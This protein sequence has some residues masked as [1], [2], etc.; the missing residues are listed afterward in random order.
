MI[1]W[2]CFAVALA[3]VFHRSCYQFC[4]WGV[5]SLVSGECDWEATGWLSKS[6]LPFRLW[7]YQPF[8]SAQ[9]EPGSRCWNGTLVIGTSSSVELWDQSE[10]IWMRQR[11]GESSCKK[12]HTLQRGSC[13]L[14]SYLVDKIAQGIL[15]NSFPLQAQAYMYN[16]WWQILTFIRLDNFVSCL[17][18]NILIE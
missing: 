9:R 16:T 1:S 14:I 10:K 5:D 15:Q 4:P 17:Q 12:W 8:P 6:S 2:Y 11:D 18:L 3:Q 7:N 13:S